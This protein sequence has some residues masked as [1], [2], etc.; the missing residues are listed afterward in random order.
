MMSGSW[1]SGSNESSVKYIKILLR[2]CCSLPNPYPRLTRVSIGPWSDPDEAELCIQRTIMQ[3]ARPALRWAFFDC[4][5]N[6]TARGKPPRCSPEEP[7]AR[8]VTF[9][10]S[11][12]RESG[13]TF[14]RR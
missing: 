13:S 2:Q 11:T 8:W 5:A 6:R 3:P 14:N 12:A 4:T 10:S 1:F 9:T 7:T